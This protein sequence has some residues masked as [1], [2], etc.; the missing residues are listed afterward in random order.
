MKKTF[1][2]FTLTF[3]MFA[4]LAR[5]QDIT[6]TFAVK[7]GTYIANGGTISPNGIHCAGTFATLG[8]TTITS[9]WAPDSSGAFASV[10][11]DVYA[12]DVVFPSTSAGDTLQFKFLNNNNWGACDVDQE[13]SIPAECSIN[14]GNRLFV[15]PAQNSIFTAAWDSCGTTTAVS[16]ISPV[17]GNITD[18]K[19]YPS[20]AQSNVSI[21]YTSTKSDNVTVALRN[22]TGQVIKVLFNGTQSAGIHNYNVDVSNLANGMYFVTAQS[23]LAMVQK[24][25]EVGK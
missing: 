5:A 21:S 2:L 18:I 20:P 16:G 7:M 14:G 3:L 11:A 19:V 4:V 22:Y 23:G 12:L 1:T 17:H 8:S 15:I 9:D 13:C 10:G 6:V 24:P 25:F